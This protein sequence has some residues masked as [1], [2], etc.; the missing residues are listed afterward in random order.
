[1]GFNI[2]ALNLI[3][4]EDDVGKVDIDNPLYEAVH[5]QAFVSTETTLLLSDGLSHVDSR[6]R[7]DILEVFVELLYVNL[8]TGVIDCFTI[9]DYTCVVRLCTHHYENDPTDENK[10]CARPS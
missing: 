5:K 3:P 1:M 2:V 6:L 9:N 10:L 7:F 4:L 8:L